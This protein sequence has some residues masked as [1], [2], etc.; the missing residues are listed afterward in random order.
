M[1]THG[2]AMFGALPTLRVKTGGKWVLVL[3]PF[4]PTHRSQLRAAS[5]ARSTQCRCTMSSGRGKV[6]QS[7]NFSPATTSVSSGQFGQSWCRVSSP[8]QLCLPASVRFFIPG[9]ACV[10][11]GRW[12]VVKLHRGETVCVCAQHFK[13][14]RQPRNTNQPLSL[15][16]AVSLPARLFRSERLIKWA[17]SAAQRLF[18]SEGNFIGGAHRYGAPPLT[19]KPRQ[20]ESPPPTLS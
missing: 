15:S 3:P 8:A 18:L 11:M 10:F 19:M 17:R 9:C 14:Q 5:R 4:L 16:A 7:E 12:R 2:A 1:D 6:W 13:T 20:G